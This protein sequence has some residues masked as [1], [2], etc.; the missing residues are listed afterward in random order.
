MIAW[1]S[2]RFLDNNYLL[3]IGIAYLFI[4][5]LD[6]IHTL[7]YAGMGVYQGYT[8]NLPTQLWIAARYAESLSLLIA[9][10]FI[11]RRLRPNLVFLSYTVVISLLVVSIF[12]NIFP[13]SYIE[14]VGLTPF[15][16]ISEYIISLILVTSIVMLFRNRTQFDRG[17][18][19]LLIVS[20]AFT[21]G[22]ELAFTFYISV[23]GFSNLV[24]HIFKITS[25]YLIY[26]ALIETGLTKPYNLLFRNLKQ[27]EEALQKANDELNVTNKEME[28]FSYSVSHDLRAP[29]RGIDGFSQVLLKN[30]SDK[31]DEQG[32]D[33]LQRVRLATQR[34]GILIDDMLSLS[35]VTRSE[36]KHELVDLS[37]LVQS[38]AAELQKSQPERQVEFIITPG[39]TAN[40]DARLLRILLENLLGNAW[41]FTGTHPKARIEFGV[42]QVGGEQVYFIRDD[43]AGFDMAYADKLFGVFQRLHRAD[44]FPGTG[45]GLATVQRVTHRHGGRVWGEGEVEKGA[46]FYFTLD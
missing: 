11:S 16:K 34:M 13:Q 35:R 36:M 41:K 22:S 40:G 30:Y 29:L 12:W 27:S 39:V 9:F 32:K 10:L 14:G 6:L 19:R 18:F 28:S 42:T 43:G 17:V 5:S 4:G 38:I 25:F 1:N 31:L 3:F 23:Y 20:I 24:G 26:K 46:T 21:I 33:Y 7:A 37:K 2:R 45:V 15:K 44:E 8:S